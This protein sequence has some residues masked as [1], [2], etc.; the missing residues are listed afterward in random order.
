MSQNYKVLN[1]S[2]SAISFAS[3]MGLRFSFKYRTRRHNKY[4][5]T[6]NGLTFYAIWNKYRECCTEP[7]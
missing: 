7:F 2:F 5:K 4:R 1:L 3:A 6:S